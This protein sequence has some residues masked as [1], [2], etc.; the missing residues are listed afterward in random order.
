MDAKNS[1]NMFKHL[2][3]QS[4]VLMESYRAMSHELHRL[5]VEEEM[6][7]QK[8]YEVMSAE[9]LLKKLCESRSSGYCHVKLFLANGIG[10]G[11]LLFNMKHVYLRMQAN[12]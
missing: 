11:A 8:L 12:M 2:E 6:L 4:E 10:Y 9:G 1:A 5:Q 7:M 3:K